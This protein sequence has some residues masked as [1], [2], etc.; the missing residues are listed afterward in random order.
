M[1]INKI[2]YKMKKKNQ[3]P[4]SDFHFSSIFNSNEFI[5]IRNF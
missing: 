3:L 5:F 4:L 2:N 1:T